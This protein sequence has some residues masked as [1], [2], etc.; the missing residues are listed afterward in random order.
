MTAPVAVVNFMK[1]EGWEC[2]KIPGGG[3]TA[4]TKVAP[5]HASAPLPAPGNAA[6]SKSWKM[7]ALNVKK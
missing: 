1:H 7:D 4:A 5:A 2:G 3:T 6:N